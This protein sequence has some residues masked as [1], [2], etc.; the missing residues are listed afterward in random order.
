MHCGDL[1]ALRETCGHV[2]AC[3]TVAFH[4]KLNQIDPNSPI[5][6][7]YEL[8]NGI[9]EFPWSDFVDGVRRDSAALP[10][11]TSKALAKPKKLVKPAVGRGVYAYHSPAAYFDVAVPDPL[12]SLRA[13]M[14]RKVL[15]VDQSPTTQ[16]P[17]VGHW[18]RALA[19]GMNNFNR[20]QFQ[21]RGFLDPIANNI[22]TPN[23]SPEAWAQRVSAGIHMRDETRW[24]RN[25]NPD[26]I[27][28]LSSDWIPTW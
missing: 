25:I 13:K 24:A 28:R 9:C 10:A 6:S 7:L 17:L 23:E 3:W 14:D 1:E 27:S 26:Y 8:G 20:F 4:V 22:N 15:T 12:E 21:L 18:D 2:C 11:L 5:N 16:S 19:A